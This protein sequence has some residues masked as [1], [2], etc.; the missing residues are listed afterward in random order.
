MSECAVMDGKRIDMNDLK[1]AISREN[2]KQS[3]SFLSQ[4]FNQNINGVTRVAK[5]SRPG[6]ILLLPV[7]FGAQVQRLLETIELSDGRTTLTPQTVDHEIQGPIIDK[8]TIPKARVDT[9][10]QNAEIDFAN[11]VQDLGCPQ[12]FKSEIVQLRQYSAQIMVCCLPDGTLC[13]EDTINLK[14]STW[15]V[16]KSFGKF[17]SI[18]H[19][20]NERRAR[21]SRSE[22][23]TGSCG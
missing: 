3:Q 12:F 1:F 20:D 14:S 23:V 19:Q 7:S 6:Q 13:G 11:F 5:S 21:N 16:H 4:A 10:L 15:R 9:A 2:G 22:A 8:Y 17:A 18:S